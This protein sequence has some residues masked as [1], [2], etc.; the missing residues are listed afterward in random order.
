M[1]Q[2]QIEIVGLVIIVLIVAVAM[3][4]YVSYSSSQR[5]EQKNFQKEYEDTELGTNFVSALLK[6]SVCNVNVNDLI[7]DCAR[8]TQRRLICEGGRGACEML[9]YTIIQIKNETL[10]KWDVSYGL[11]IDFSLADKED[12]PWV[13]TRYNCTEDTVGSRP[14]SP[15]TTRL[16][17]TNDYTQVALGICES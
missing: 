5:A 6:T 4:F 17:P 12:E 7:T 16:H 3:L 9:N 15:F 1:K 13:Y 11:Y 10:D 8:G 2:G 14:V